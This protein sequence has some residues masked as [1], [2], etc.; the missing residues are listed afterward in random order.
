MDRH[1]E[2]RF[3][4]HN[5]AAAADWPILV[6]FC[7]GKQFFRRIS[8]IGQTA[9]FHRSIPCYSNALWA[10]AIGGFSYRLRYTCY[11]HFKSFH[12]IEQIKFNREITKNNNYKR[13]TAR[14]GNSRKKYR[15][16]ETVL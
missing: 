8:A 15:D 1:I 10:S 5:S 4:G 6:K 11:H 3:F 14:R 13:I 12:F 16:S 2:N 7:A 9:A